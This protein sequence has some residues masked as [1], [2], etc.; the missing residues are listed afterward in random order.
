MADRSTFLNISGDSGLYLKQ[1]SSN[2]RMVPCNGS[3]S[4]NLG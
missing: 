4:G 2:C 3:V 1:A